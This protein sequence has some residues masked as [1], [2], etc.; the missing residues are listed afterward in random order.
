LAEEPRPRPPR[1]DAFAPDEIG[2]RESLSLTV[3]IGLPFA[4]EHS[5]LFIHRSRL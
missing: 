5:E 4:C 3:E 1:R 2:Q